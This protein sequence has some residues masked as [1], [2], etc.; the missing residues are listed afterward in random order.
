MQT[1]ETLAPIFIIVFL[2]WG[3]RRTGFLSPEFF[4]GMNKLTFYVGLPSLLFYKISTA[5]KGETKA[6]TVFGVMLG[7]MV[8]ILI[9]SYFVGRWLRLPPKSRGVFQQATYR[10]NLAFVGLP[11][12]LYSLNGT[13]ALSRTE[14]EAIALLSIVPMIPVYNIV[15]V[16][17]LQGSS[18]DPK[19][20]PA[21]FVVQGLTTPLVL[22]CLAGAAFLLLEIPLPVF[23][24]RSFNAV[25]QM[26]LPLALLGI[27]ATLDRKRIRG[28]LALAIGASLLKTAAVPLIGWG[29]ALWVGL[30]SD[31]LRIALIYLATP[32]AATSFVMAEQ[33]GGDEVLAGSCVVISTLLSA[34]SLTV[35]LTLF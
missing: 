31:E 12:I 5:S 8:I 23:L 19:T 26:A 22:A 14:A 25:G 27:G 28:N 15:A 11:V 21:R 3:L 33:L 13:H 7:A 10:G 18:K 24:G 32:T 1:I 16:L 35:V 4:L 34:I 30:D 2:G 20:S 29:I 6:F 17:L 9:V